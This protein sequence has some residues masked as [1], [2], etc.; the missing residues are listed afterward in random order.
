MFLSEFLNELY[1]QRAIKLHHSNTKNKQKLM[2]KIYCIAHT[3]QNMSSIGKDS[4]Q[5]S[6][7]T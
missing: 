1:N 3:C 4:T 6:I 5:V 7:L 2:Y